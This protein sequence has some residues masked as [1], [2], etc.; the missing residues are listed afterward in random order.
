MT[1]Q[2]TLDAELDELLSESEASASERASASFDQLAGGKPLVLFGAGGIGRK[3]AAGL[4]RL[5]TPP[6]AFSDNNPQLWGTQIQGIPVLSP[7]QAAERYGKTAAFLVTIWRGEGTDR[8]GDHLRQLAELG[9]DVAFPFGFLYW[10]HAS[11]FLPHY[12]LDVP[13]KVLQQ[14]DAVRAAFQRFADPQ[15]RREFL[16]QLH[17]RLR[18]N[19]DGLADPVQHEI[20]FPEDV[21]TPR[22]DEVFVDCG[23]YDGDTLQALLARPGSD[24]YQAIALEPDPASYGKLTAFCQSLPPQTQQRI[25][26][27]AYGAGSEAGTA[28][29]DATGLPS[30]SRS[31]SGTLIEIETLDRL[32]EQQPCTYLKMDIE[33]AEPDALIGARKTIHR[34]HPV[35]AICVYHQ[36]DHL[37]KIPNLI[38]SFADDYDFLLRPH[39]L[40]VWD[41]V[42]YAIPK[43]RRVSP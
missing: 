6:L 29:F 2:D 36:Q 17:W 24:Q 16:A 15:S 23:A 10:K 13:Q 14:R 38:A 35:L 31:D 11:A 7:Q 4:T 3:T 5:G 39:L 42:C 37:W 32:L 22:A 27:L 43:S 28:Y 33:G 8:M 30:A 26:T 34:D 18:L 40:E 9:C 19:F 25:K 41:L 21:C 20:Y 1:V 12:A